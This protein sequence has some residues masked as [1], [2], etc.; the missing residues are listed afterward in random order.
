MSQQTLREHMH[1]IDKRLRFRLRLYFIIAAVL[2]VIMLFNF[3]RGALRF[4]F[5]I[6]SLLIG[7]GIGILA[8]RMYH[9]SWNHDAQKVVSRLDMFGIGILVLYAVFE[10]SREKIVGFFTHNLEVGAVGLALLAGI[11]FGRVI[12]TRGKILEV[13]KEQKVFG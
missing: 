5:G 9:I 8:S 11:M 7:I 10:L 6:I 13:L 3:A 12:G 1:H 2:I 4:D